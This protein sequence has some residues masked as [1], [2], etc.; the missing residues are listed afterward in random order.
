MLRSTVVSRRRL[1]L[2][3]T[4]AESI[5]LSICLFNS[6][7]VV[8]A[9]STTFN[10]TSNMTY[11]Q[12][13]HVYLNEITMS[14]P[15]STSSMVYQQENHIYINEISMSE[16]EE[17]STT[18]PGLNDSTT[19]TYLTQRTH[20]RSSY[21]GPDICISGGCFT[22]ISFH[23]NRLNISGGTFVDTRSNDICISGGCFINFPF[24]ANH[25]NISGGTFVETCSND[26]RTTTKSGE[27]RGI[28]VMK[29]RTYKTYYQ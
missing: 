16:A 4:A 29:R 23:A 20:A 24:H 25:L 7:F 15:D 1:F 21:N 19:E 2:I 18:D 14:E 8:S 10:S 26:T 9:F 17:N 22:N 27:S 3:G 12:E 11:Q 6:S 5:Y 28:V 13:N